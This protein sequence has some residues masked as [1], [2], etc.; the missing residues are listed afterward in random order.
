MGERKQIRKEKKKKGISRDSQIS[1]LIFIQVTWGIC[2]KS[3]C[4]GPAYRDAIDLK[5]DPGIWVG[6]RQPF[7]KY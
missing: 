5:T 2:L 6:L 7:K 4:I 1:I 3:R